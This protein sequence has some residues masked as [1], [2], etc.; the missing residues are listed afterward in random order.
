MQDGLH[1]HH[2]LGG[3]TDP[4][5]VWG[6]H[7]GRMPCWSC[8][9]GRERDVRVRYR[10]SWVDLVGEQRL[11]RYVRQPRPLPGQRIVLLSTAFGNLQVHQ[12][13]HRHAHV[14]QPDMERLLLPI[15]PY[16]VKVW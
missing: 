13:L 11:D 1:R 6:V 3:V 2:Q 9:G 4:F 12:W 5:M 16:V 15:E 14:G 8:Q 7:G 10:L